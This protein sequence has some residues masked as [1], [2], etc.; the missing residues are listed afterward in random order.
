MKVFKSVLKLL[1][2]IGLIVIVGY[3][4]FTLQSV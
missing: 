3:F 1:I 2:F 4:V